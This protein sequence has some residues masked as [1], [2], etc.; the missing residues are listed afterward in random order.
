MPFI[1]IIITTAISD[2]QIICNILNRNNLCIAI[3][4]KRNSI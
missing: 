3:Q 2:Y 4:I 1:F